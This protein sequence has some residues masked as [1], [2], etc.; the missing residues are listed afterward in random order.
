MAAHSLLEDTVPFPLP[1]EIK[2]TPPPHDLVQTLLLRTLLSVRLPPLGP[3]SSGLTGAMQH[4]PIGGQR[5]VYTSITPVPDT[6]WAWENCCDL[7]QSIKSE[8]TAEEEE[9]EEEE[10]AAC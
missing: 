6:S 9:E 10:E 2:P 4:K 8:I 3:P 1:E 5:P 7:V